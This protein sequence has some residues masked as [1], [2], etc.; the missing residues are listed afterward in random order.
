MTNLT[1][2]DSAVLHARLM[3][4]GSYAKVYVGSQRVA[5]VPNAKLGESDSVRFEI[6]VASPDSSR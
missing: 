1:G 2:A 5:N 4:D 3:V 6:G